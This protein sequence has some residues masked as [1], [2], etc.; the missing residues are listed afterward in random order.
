M[1]FCCYA[2]SILLH[3][4]SSWEIHLP[5]RNK[6]ACSSSSLESGVTNN[7]INPC[8][9][10]R[11]HY[12]AKENT[13]S[14]KVDGVA[15][16]VFFVSICLDCLRRD[17][18]LL[19]SL[20]LFWINPP[21]DIFYSILSIAGENS[22]VSFVCTD[23]LQFFGSDRFRRRVVFGSSVLLHLQLLP[24]GSTL[25]WPRPQPNRSRHHKHPCANG[26]Q[27]AVVS[28]QASTVQIPIECHRAK[29]YQQ[30]DVVA[31]AAYYR[32][33]LNQQHTKIL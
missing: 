6:G 20:S 15:P 27:P 33:Q 9:I 11:W 1:L 19:W 18:P 32:K 17:F 10:V 4:I 16:S 26:N 30:K 22:C 8:M 5:H 7:N 25:E 3:Q 28:G 21:I 23:A 31:R 29:R 2:L 12:R 14:S 24:I 13:P